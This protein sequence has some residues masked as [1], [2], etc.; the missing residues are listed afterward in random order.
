M[1]L[2]SNLTLA[3]MLAGWISLSLAGC[4]LYKQASLSLDLA[5]P[6]YYEH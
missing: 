4:L 3:A 5:V 2:S 6:P 1:N